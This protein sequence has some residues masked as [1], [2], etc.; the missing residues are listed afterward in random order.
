M[1]LIVRVLCGERGGILT[2]A[3]RHEMLDCKT[4][5]QSLLWLNLLLSDIVGDAKRHVNRWSRK[6]CGFKMTDL[7]VEKYVGFQHLK[8]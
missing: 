7:V 3:L 4:R 8:H 6:G 5:P 2:S 1:C